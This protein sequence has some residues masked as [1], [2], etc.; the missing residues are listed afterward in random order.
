MNTKVRIA[1]S[2]VAA[3]ALLLVLFNAP[4]DGESG[5]SPLADETF[6]ERAA[7]TRLNT[8]GSRAEIDESN[9]TLVERAARTRAAEL[10]ERVESEP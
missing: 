7:R 3:A 1:I 8:D 4:G 10:V 6:V 9:E 5:A 2:L